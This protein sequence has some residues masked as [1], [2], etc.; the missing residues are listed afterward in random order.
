MICNYCNS[1]IRP[2]TGKMYVT[3]SGKIYFFCSSKCEKYFLMKRSLKA[4][5]W[6]KDENKNRSK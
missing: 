2:G 4:H 5:K 1:K 3:S 6:Q